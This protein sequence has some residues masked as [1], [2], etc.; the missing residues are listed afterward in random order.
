MVELTVITRWHI[1]QE[2]QLVI[3][4][5]RTILQRIDFHLKLERVEGKRDLVG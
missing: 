5:E 3:K 2:I 1:Q 4:S